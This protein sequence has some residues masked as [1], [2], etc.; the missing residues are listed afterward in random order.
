L[1]HERGN[2]AAVPRTGEG[3]KA[4]GRLRNPAES[5]S[6]CTHHHR[7]RIATHNFTRA[8]KGGGHP[9]PPCSAS[10]PR[11]VGNN[12]VRPSTIGGAQRRPGRAWPSQK[13]LS[14]RRGQNPRHSSRRVGP[15]KFPGLLD[16][17]VEKT[18]I[19]H[20]WEK[21]GP[22]ADRDVAQAIWAPLASYRHRK[23]PRGTWTPL[24]S[25]PA[26]IGANRLGKSITMPGEITT[27][28]RTRGYRRI[29]RIHW[30]RARN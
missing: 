12:P 14:C 4:I 18:G 28:E 21:H 25:G 13:S 1:R 11:Q 5:I 27:G 2:S 24:R 22:S 16:C 26:A 10:S 7:R 15:G 17:P 6:I 29:G 9:P 20:D 30:H 23:H 19:G 3:C 8:Q